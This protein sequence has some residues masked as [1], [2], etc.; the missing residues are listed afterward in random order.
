MNWLGGIFKVLLQFGANYLETW[1]KN[2]KLKELEY[3]KK[4]RDAQLKSVG[5]AKRVEIDIKRAAETAKP[6][7][8]VADWNA[9]AVLLLCLLPWFGGCA[10]FTHTVY[11]EA[12]RPIIE[13]P[14]RPQLATTPAFSER[15]KKLAGHAVKLESAIKAYNADARAKNKKNG[16]E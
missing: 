16:F 10:L 8:T 15:E 3:A 2:E 9:G 7:V 1:Y 12:K 6:P 14:K 4:A 5:A 13:I 11:V